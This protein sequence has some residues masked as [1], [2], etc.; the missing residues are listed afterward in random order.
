MITAIIVDD[1]Q[2]S[3]SLLQKILA[4][5]FTEIVILGTAENSRKAK[6]LITEAK[7]QLVFLDV[8]MPYGSGFDL[9]KSFSVIDFE[10]IFITAF[11]QYTLNAFRFSALDYLLKP[12]NILQLKEAL[13]KV[14][15]SIEQKSSFENY[16]LLLQ[17]LNEQDIGEQKIILTD[18]RGQH[19][20]K[21]NDICYCIADGSYTEVHLTNSKI[22][23]S[24]K[25]L[26][27][28]EDLLPKELFCR[29]HHGH[30]I[31]I[32]HIA[33]IVKG[34]GGSVLMKD[35]KELEIAVRRKENLLKLCVK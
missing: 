8:E 17:N 33:K 21:L 29:I 35:G 23:I 28:F 27:E 4:D 34:R 32:N 7:P 22:F 26:K 2:K 11:N 1:E 5:Y 12:I 25:N 15:V 24:S 20:F 31:H 3:V 13:N 14:K 30:I 16:R 19:F 10:V 9:L 18:N 6:E